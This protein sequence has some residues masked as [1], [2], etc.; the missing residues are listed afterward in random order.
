LQSGRPNGI[1]PA[2]DGNDAGVDDEHGARTT[3]L[4]RDWHPLHIE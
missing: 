2:H 3:I 1:A 4:V